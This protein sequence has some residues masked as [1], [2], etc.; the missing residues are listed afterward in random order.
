MKNFINSITA[1]FT[2]VN[3]GQM[4]LALGVAF[5]LG[6]L[7]LG[8][9]RATFRGVIFSRGFAFALVM[10]AMIASMIVRV[11][12]TN[13]PLSLG[14]AGALCVVRFRTTL[15]DPVDNVFLLW[16]IAAGI[17]SG[18]GYYIPALI[19]CVILAVLYFICTY[20]FKKSVSPYLLVIR[21]APAA[22]TAVV[23]EVKKLNRSRLKSR[24]VT[25]AGNES[26]YEVSL[27]G[28]EDALVDNLK[29]IPGVYDVS[30]ISYESEFG[31]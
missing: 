16:S 14:V 25:D 8:V 1:Q 7:I 15:K 26:T 23:R 9:Y 24:V 13:V 11:A 4:I 6:L 3:L 22:G 29:S 5:L 21:Y 28:K 12:T 30:L 31:L 19:A 10:F 18:A 20:I 17:M 27:T 2:M